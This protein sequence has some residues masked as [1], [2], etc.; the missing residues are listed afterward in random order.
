MSRNPHLDQFMRAFPH[1]ALTFDDVSLSAEYADFLPADADLS[2]RLT[3]RIGLNIPML[4]SAMD[5]VTEARMAIS[6]AMLGGI[7]IVHKN[8]TPDKQASIV[9]D[10]K[11]YLNGLIANPV[12]FRADQTLAD[13]QQTREAK[14]Y[15]FSGF[16]ILD[17]R[18]RLVGILTSS[19]IKY[20]RDRRAPIHQVM[21]SDPHHR[22]A[23]HLAAAGVRGHAQAQDRQAAAG[24]ERQAD[25]ALQ[26]LRCGDPDSQRAAAVQPRRPVPPARRR[27]HRPPATR[28]GWR[29]WPP[30]RWTWWWW[31]RPTATPRACWR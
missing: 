9:R 6:M 14:G 17:D 12:T 23:R 2:T 13:V 30:T 19:D 24:G 25:R 31:T 18:D 15:T 3:T 29:R 5:T 16:P 20:A 28:P 7:G 10:V 27:R 22:P 21:T 4:S 26:L 11:H 1:E 8:L